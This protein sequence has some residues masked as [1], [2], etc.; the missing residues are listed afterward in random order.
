MTNDA[1]RTIWADQ[2]QVFDDCDVWHSE[3][4]EGRTEY[5]RADIAQAEKEAAVAAEREACAEVCYEY[6][7]DHGSGM[8]D[9][10][11]AECANRIRARSSVS[12]ANYAKTDALEAVRQEARAEALREAAEACTYVIKNYELVSKES[13]KYLPLKTQK[14]ARG[15]VSLAREDILALIPDTDKGASDG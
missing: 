12:C 11:S 6:S 1:P 10:H 14:A 13:G 15:M 9:R 8:F 3:P 4:A 7:K 5:I 2:P